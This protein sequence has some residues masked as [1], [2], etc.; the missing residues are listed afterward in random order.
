MQQYFKFR[1]HDRVMIKGRREH[2]Y[3]IVGYKI[4]K[5]V[6]L[7]EQWI[8]VIYEIYREDDGVLMAVMEEDLELSI[9]NQK[10][11][12]K[13]VELDVNK[14]LDEYNDYL[15]LAT[16]FEDATYVEKMKIILDKMKNIQNKVN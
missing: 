10:V 1:L 3:R 12:T 6:K 15:F 4:E 13:N 5:N 11:V 14:L 8:C 9:K 7:H 16:F 2:D